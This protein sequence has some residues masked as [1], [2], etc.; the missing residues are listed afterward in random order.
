MSLVSQVRSLAPTAQD[1]HLDSFS[2]KIGDW[3][4]N[5]T[6]PSSANEKDD[7]PSGFA[8]GPIDGV[9]IDH[10]VA[11]CNLINIPV[12][13]LYD[14]ALQE[15]TDKVSDATVKSLLQADCDLRAY[16]QARKIGDVYE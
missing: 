15:L 8:C 4:F 13:H 5:A 6:V 10:V 2:Q 7:V 11:A 14:H 3:A 1:D 12:A 16:L 9:V